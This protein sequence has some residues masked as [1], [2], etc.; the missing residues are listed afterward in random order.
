MHV[1]GKIVRM[2]Q[3]QT[4]QGRAGDYQVQGVLL[5]LAQEPR[6]QVYV[7]LFPPH[8]GTFQA[9][10][11][12]FGRELEGDLVFSTAER[13]GFVSNYVELQNPRIA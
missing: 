12:C 7:S 5:E 9:Q 8:L 2:G 4:R 6:Q 3:V 13:N 1:K 11:P 10:Q